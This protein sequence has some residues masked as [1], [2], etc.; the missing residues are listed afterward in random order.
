MCGER[1]HLGSLALVGS[2]SKAGRGGSPWTGSG[3]DGEKEENIGWALRI[4][5]TDMRG[6]SQGV[7]ITGSLA[8]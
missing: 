1:S 5:V 4:D 7:S 3:Q 8:A 2:L 6:H